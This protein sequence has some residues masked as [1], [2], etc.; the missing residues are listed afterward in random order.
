MLVCNVPTK[1]ND[2]KYLAERRD[3]AQGYSMSFCKDSAERRLK[4]FTNDG[5][6]RHIGNIQYTWRCLSPPV[7]MALAPWVYMKTLHGQNLQVR[8]PESEVEGRQA[9]CR[10]SQ[11]YQD[12]CQINA[13][14]L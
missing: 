3:L 6:D 11:C 9:K 14:V 4:T 12:F 2:E 5:R 8:T 10:S 7:S 13:C 1:R